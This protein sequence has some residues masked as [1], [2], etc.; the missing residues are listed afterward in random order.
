[1]RDLYFY[2]LALILVGAILAVAILPGRGQTGLSA[3]QIR[4]DGYTLSGDHLRKLT[5]A[6]GTVATFSQNQPGAFTFAVL[7]TN[8]PRGIVEP[9][10]GVFAT[11]GTHYADVFTGEQIKV[12]VRARRGRTHPLQTLQF[13]YFTVVAGNSGWRDFE[14]SD[15]FA[16]YSFIYSPAP[17]DGPNPVHYVGIWPGDGG[18][19]ETVEIQNIRVEILADAG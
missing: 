16:D 12:T 2:P 8:L 15:T 17:H 1:M 13:A 7:S 5:Q 18:K 3:A 4:Q 19:N 11:L 14:L 9:S 6:P 10:A